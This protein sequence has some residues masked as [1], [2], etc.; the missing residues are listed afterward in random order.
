MG[1]K[2]VHA[3]FIP[4][5]SVDIKS[6]A[7]RLKAVMDEHDCVNIFL[8]E[9]AGVKDIVA[10]MEAAGQEVPR[11][12]FGHVKLDKVNP[13]QWFAAQFGP[14]IGAEKVLV[15]K[16]GYFARSA[17]ANQRDRA[18]IESCAALAV[19]VALK[20]E[21]GCVGHDEERGDEL[22]AIEFERIKGGKAFDVEL[23]V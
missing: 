1:K 6:E 22:R 3:V 10:Q 15:Q 8:S 17:A 5:I 13:G 21:S 23:L 20:G 16:S 12:A 18:L 14:M 2:D 7:A 9:G 11:D 4:E 19:T